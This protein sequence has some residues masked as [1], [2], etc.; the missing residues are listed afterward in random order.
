[1]KKLIIILAIVFPCNVL[2][3]FPNVLAFVNHH[4]ITKYD[5]E[6]R[7]NIIAV[8][9]NIDFSDNSIDIRQINSNILNILI[10]EETLK[11]YS[12]QLGN[13]VGEQEIDNA[14]SLM[15]KKNNMQKGGIKQYLTSYDLDINSFR[16]QVQG[17][18]IKRNIINSLSQSIYITNNEIEMILVNQQQEFDIEG[19]IFTLKSSDIKLLD[20]IKSLIKTDLLTC[21]LSSDTISAHFINS[22]KIVGK[23]STFSS[24]IQSVIVDTNLDSF[25]NIFKQGD[26]FQVVFLCK[27][28]YVLSKEDLEKIKLFLFEK[29]IFKK[30]AKFFQELKMNSCVQMIY[31]PS[32]L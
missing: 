6:S 18:L 21:N 20:N 13:I 16:Q 27:K 9:N 3:D 25:S 30:S 14:I 8:L 31:H 29:K 22:Q 7:K 2:S 4:P 5:L 28:D 26:V 23:L 1:M 15:E 17:E 24:R 32:G 11:Q 10:E 12:D 19:W